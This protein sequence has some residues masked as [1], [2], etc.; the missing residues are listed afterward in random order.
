MFISLNK[1]KQE[2]ASLIQMLLF[3]IFY[4]KNYYSLYKSESYITND[5]LVYRK[6]FYKSIAKKNITHIDQRDNYEF[7]IHTSNAKKYTVRILED[8][9]VENR[10][11]IKALILNLKA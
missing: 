3:A 7:I 4:Y 2:L 6:G 1:N 10:E 11:A 8:D 5:A 9:K